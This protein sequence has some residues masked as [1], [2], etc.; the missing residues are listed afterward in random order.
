[1]GGN[2]VCQAPR[3]WQDAWCMVGTQPFFVEGRK[4][5]KTRKG[6]RGALLEEVNECVGAEQKRA[7]S[8]TQTS[9]EPDGSQSS[10]Q[11]RTSPLPSS[12]TGLAK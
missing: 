7:A 4:E 12:C 10:S 8:R 11:P 2:Q 5:G 6:G 9:L 3:A 1:M